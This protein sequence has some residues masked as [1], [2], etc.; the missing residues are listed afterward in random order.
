MSI[1]LML[2]IV[3]YSLDTLSMIDFSY[4]ETPSLAKIIEEDNSKEPAVMLKLK[5]PLRS[6]LRAK[7]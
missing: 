6:E 1:A 5:N 2:K 3:K 4:Q 7:R